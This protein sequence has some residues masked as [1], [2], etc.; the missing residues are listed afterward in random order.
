MTLLAPGLIRRLVILLALVGCANGPL[1][2]PAGR[3]APQT[4]AGERALQVEDFGD[5]LPTAKAVLATCAG[6]AVA[7]QQWIKC[8]STDGCYSTRADAEATRCCRF[9]KEGLR[10][11]QDPKLGS[12]EVRG[13][14]VCSPKLID[15]SRVTVFATTADWSTNHAIEELAR[16]E[17]GPAAVDPVPLHEE[18]RLPYALSISPEGLSLIPEDEQGERRLH[19]LGLVTSQDGPAVAAFLRLS[20]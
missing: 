7:E 1:M 10:V 6:D 9:S 8:S 5:D 17:L 19:L 11:S 12:L 16:F 14:L 4:V 3:E 13:T 2:E 15:A 20:F 18:L